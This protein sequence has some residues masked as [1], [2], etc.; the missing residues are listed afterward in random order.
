MLAK[1]RDP[2]ESGS[3][4]FGGFGDWGKHFNAHGMPNYSQADAQ[5]MFEE[6]ASLHAFYFELEF[7]CTL[8][9]QPFNPFNRQE[10]K[11]WVEWEECPISMECRI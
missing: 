3:F 9:Y 4:N 6:M 11:E 1:G 7:F 10:C 5:R 2:E 8:T